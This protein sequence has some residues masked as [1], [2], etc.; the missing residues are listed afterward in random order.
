MAHNK[1]SDVDVPEGI[2]F[3][4]LVWEQEDTCEVKTNEKVLNLGEKAPAC[5]EHMGTVLSLLDRMASCWWACQEG[6]HKIERLCGRVASNARAALRLLR[7]GFYDESLVL[8]RAMGETANLLYLFT[9]D[10]S[11][12]ED[13]KASSQAE[14]QSKFSPVKVRLRLEELQTSPPINQDRYKLL[15]QRAAHPNPGTSPQSHNFLGVPTAGAI[16]QEEGI[17]V[18][19]NEIALPL[20]VATCFG[21]LL[22]DLENN[23]KKRV[24]IAARHLA[25]QIGRAGITEIDDYHRYALG[26]V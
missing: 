24:V 10:D 11:A 1:N 22:L 4:E 12:L 26:S 13:W 2:A 19:L 5:L 7:F 15:S 6:D 18:C 17:V 25:E 14:L 21:A 20:S 16:M 3:L 8:S 23:V 9:Q